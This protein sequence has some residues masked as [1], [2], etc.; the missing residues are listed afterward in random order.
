LTGSCTGPE[1]ASPGGTSPVHDRFTQAARRAVV[2]ADE[3]ACSLGHNYIGTEHLLL[4]LLREQEGVAVRALEALGVAPDRARERVIHVVGSREAS[5]G[6]RRPLT[7]RACRAL[8]LASEEAL[9][10][11]HDCVGSGHLLL[12]LVR[13]SRGVAAQVLYRLGVDPDGVRRGVARIPDD[14]EETT[15]GNI[16]R[17]MDLPRA[18]TFRTRVEGLVVQ[19]RCGVT[20]EERALPQALR[21][22]LDYLYEAGEGDYLLKTVDYGA[23]IEG[24]AGLLEREEFRLL[25]TGARMVGE[26]VLDRFPPVREVTVA[27]TKLR[28]PVARE[29]SGVSV[30][31]TFG[32]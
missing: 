22:D 20:D 10:L 25:E 30:E 6:D 5:T 12:G 13:E 23:L 21:V 16:G 15:V 26:H 31:A 11:G 32:R 7:P 4:G 18:K 24:V 28:V 17:V 1:E 8:E 14:G 3:E 9:H 27:V 2:L 29:V 19:A